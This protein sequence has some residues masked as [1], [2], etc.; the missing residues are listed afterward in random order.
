MTR[1][2]ENAPPLSHGQRGLDDSRS[3][4]SIP[5]IKKKATAPNT[6]VCED[7]DHKSAVAHDTTT[8]NT[9]GR[10]PSGIDL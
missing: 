9:E 5:T 10:L 7:P 3:F 1:I 4:E 8:P 2:E 6:V